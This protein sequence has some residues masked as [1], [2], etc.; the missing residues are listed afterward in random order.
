MTV[1]NIAITSD[2]I[3]PWC[4]VGYK[5][6]NKGIQLFEKVYPGAKDDQ[7]RFTWKPYFLNRDPPPPGQAIPYQ[8][9]IASRFGPE[10]AKLVQQ[11]LATIGYQ[12]GISFGFDGF[13]GDTKPSHMLMRYAALAGAAN[14]G[15]AQGASALQNK[16]VEALFQAQFEESKDISSTDTLL[17]IA[18][19]AGLDA[20][21]VKAY[22]EDPKNLD[23]VW[24]EEKRSTTEEHING[25]PHYVVTAEGVKG[26]HRLGGAEPENEWVNL[27]AEVKKEEAEV[28]K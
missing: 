21:E 20:Q 22:L 18:E 8:E 3:C 2:S 6:L 14:G 7:F 27:F 12:E 10:K 25:V 1:F 16:T 26:K 23:A 11:R 9:R 19:R 15:G 5:R 4:Y 24:E 28:A 13:D 17:D